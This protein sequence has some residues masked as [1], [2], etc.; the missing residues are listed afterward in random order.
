VVVELFYE[1]LNNG[2]LYAMDI[3]YNSIMIE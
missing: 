2:G 3:A 1:H